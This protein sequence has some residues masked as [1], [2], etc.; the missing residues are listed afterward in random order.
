MKDVL[1]IWREK[2]EGDKVWSSIMN[3]LKNSRVKDI[4]I[5]CIDGLKGFPDAIEAVFPKTEVQLYIDHMI[6]NSLRFVARKEPKKVASDLKK[7]YKD[8]TEE[9]GQMNL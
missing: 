7:V 3:E 9:E 8:A 1:G 4:F 2:T 6:R 5:A